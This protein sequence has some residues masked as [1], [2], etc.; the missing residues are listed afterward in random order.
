[1]VHRCSSS[2]LPGRRWTPGLPSWSLMSA[3]PRCVAAQTLPIPLSQHRSLLFA[4]SPS[5]RHSISR[6]VTIDCYQPAPSSSPSPIVV[7][8]FVEQ[9]NEQVYPTFSM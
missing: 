5:R 7:K 2:V 1:M 3:P 9:G 4:S 6:P 8:I